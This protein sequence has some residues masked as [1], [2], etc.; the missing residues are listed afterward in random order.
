LNPD[1]PGAARTAALRKLAGL[2]KLQ[3][4]ELAVADN[5]EV[6]TLSVFKQLQGLTLIVPA[7][8]SCSVRGL[9][10]LAALRQLQCLQLE[11]PG[12]SCSVWK[13]EDLLLLL[14]SSMR[15]VKTAYIKVL[16]KDFTEV[17]Y[18]VVAAF[19]AMCEQGLIEDLHVTDESAL[20]ERSRTGFLLGVRP[21]LDAGSGDE[22]D[23]N[24]DGGSEDEG[25]DAAGAGGGNADGVG[26]G[27]EDGAAAGGGGEGAG[28][29]AADHHGDGDNG[30]VG[31]DAD[32]D[33]VD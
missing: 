28:D 25:D 2:Q 22:G 19:E 14:L 27:G 24:D 30:C 23:G 26:G 1:A 13:D 32:D 20:L 4:M 21:L 11:V 10:L 29:G 33:G 17:Y 3:Q 8:S 12:K 15:H 7:C 16:E 9:P 6:A 5:A 18:A 31:A